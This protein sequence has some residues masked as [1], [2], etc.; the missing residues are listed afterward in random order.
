MP[1]KL[2]GTIPRWF[3][4][5]LTTFLMFVAVVAMALGWW[6]DR[7][8]FQAELKKRD[9]WITIWRLANDPSLNQP[10]WLAPPVTAS[11]T[12]PIDP[13]RLLRWV[14]DGPEA[15]RSESP[16]YF[17]PGSNPK[18]AIPDLYDALQHP[19]SQV[20]SRAAYALPEV[21]ACE[22]TSAGE[23]QG[24]V[25][26]LFKAFEN[27]QNEVARKIIAKAVGELELFS[28]ERDY[29]LEV[30]AT[31]PDGSSPA[32]TPAQREDATGGSK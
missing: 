25:S 17:E 16:R 19:D 27:E 31:A 3:Q 32:A 29:A 5:R 12:D 20:R 23:I 10:L 1:R 15:N 8:R 2:S 13:D 22:G 24:T 18:V 30:R 21:V 14:H 28:M 11:S 9:A 4:F 26:R 6:S 7:Q